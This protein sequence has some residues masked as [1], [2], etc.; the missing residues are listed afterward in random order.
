MAG[1][2][3]GSVWEL[4]P[5]FP[6]FFLIPSLSCFYFHGLLQLTCCSKAGAPNS[7]DLEDDAVV[8]CTERIMFPLGKELRTGWMFCFE[9]TA[10]AFK[11]CFYWD[12][13]RVLLFLLLIHE[14]FSSSF[15]WL[16]FTKYGVLERVVVKYDMFSFLL[17]SALFGR[18]MYCTRTRRLPASSRPER[19]TFVC[20]QCALTRFQRFPLTDV[21]VA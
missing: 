7:K 14:L 11:C 5:L 18:W 8:Y 13:S 1:F 19:P 10:M 6:C 15:T 17:C 20:L 4:W 16:H 21:L 3:A 2:T 9:S 12:R